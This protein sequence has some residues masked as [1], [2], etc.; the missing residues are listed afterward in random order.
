LTDKELEEALVVLAWGNMTAGETPQHSLKKWYEG[1]HPTTTAE[2]A[3]HEHMADCTGFPVCRVDMKTKN[4]RAAGS[5]G[6]CVECSHIMNI[7]CI[8]CKKWLCDPQLAASR[9]M[10]SDDPKYIKITF[11]DGKLSG[12]EKRICTIYSCWHKSYPAALEANGALAR[13]FHCSEQ[14]ESEIGSMG[15]Y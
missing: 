5:R 7:F 6:H 14:F 11:D 1:I 8:L 10:Q 13:G 4:N 12:K 3:V 9:S 2:I 15:S